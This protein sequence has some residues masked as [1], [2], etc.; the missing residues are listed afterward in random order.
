MTSENIKDLSKRIS[1]L[2]L[3]EAKE[4]VK[5]IKQNLEISDADLAARTPAPAPAPASNKESEEGA[6][7]V[8][9][10]AFDAK[11]KLKLIKRLKDKFGYGL[12]SA[13]EAVG[14]LPCTIKS[15]MAKAEAT[16]SVEELKDIS[17]T[18]EIKPAQ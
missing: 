16:K 8:I 6:F 7:D 3:V 15:G 4:L 12:N 1:K 2:T 9:I 18:V 5:D 14:K 10:T 13:K 11:D 17:A